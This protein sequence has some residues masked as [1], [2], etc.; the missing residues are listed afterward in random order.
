[1]FIC[2]IT[3]MREDIEFNM[4]TLTKI[5]SVDDHDHEHDHNHDHDHDVDTDAGRVVN[6]MK[7]KIPVSNQNGKNNE[8]EIVNDGK[9][10]LVVTK[11][12]L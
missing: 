4:P 6:P 3:L 5:V 2:G 7:I 8:L 1:M 12:S 10:S 11:L 9:Y